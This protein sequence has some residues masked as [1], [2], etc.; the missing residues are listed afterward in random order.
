MAFKTR[1]A[2]FAL[3]L[4]LVLAGCADDSTGDNTAPGDENTAPPLTSADTLLAGAPDNRDLAAEGKAD[5]VYPPEYSE[6]VALQSPIRNQ[7]HRGVCSIFSTVALMEHLYIKEGTYQNPDFSEQYL[8]WAAKFQVNAFPDTSGSNA[9]SNLEAITDYGIVEESVWPYEKYQWGTSDD[10]E[11]TGDEMPTR[12][13]TNGEP[14]AEAEA[15]EKFKLP[16]S[17]WVSTRPND[18]K[19]YMT[20]HEAAV[21]VGLTFFYQAW[22][23]GGSSLPI[24]R[25]YSHEGYVLYPNDADKE[26]SLEHRAGHSILLV[27]W[28]DNLEVQRLDKDGEPMVDDNGD[29]VMEKGFFIFKN[30]WGTGS[31]GRDNPNGDGY[32]Y[33][34][35]KY[36][37]EY[38]H[39][40]VAEMPEF[41]EQLDEICGDGLDNDEN[42]DT[43]CQDAAC[44]DEPACQPTNDTQTYANTDATAI[45]D[46]DSDGIKSTIDIADG[47]TIADLSVTVDITH[48]YSGDLNVILEHPN[49]DIVILAESGDSSE[50]NIQKTF[51]VDDFVGLDAQGTWTLHVWDEAQYDEGTLNEW[52]LEVTY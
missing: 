31:F 45:P 2:P 33:I 5:A 26:A 42:G 44:S 7:G 47:G 48:P 38:G 39:A 46:N 36:V 34:S 15:A 8:Q 17:R 23:H 4:M 6:L 3:T 35:M 49:G 43:D 52:S 11:C 37:E 20:E 50:D 28:D 51:T 32:G 1:F 29:P 21:I 9:S 40:R 16:S 14:P 27:G 12:C 19:A 10:P 22:N 25:D 24:S 30:S 41:A 13:Y 18:I